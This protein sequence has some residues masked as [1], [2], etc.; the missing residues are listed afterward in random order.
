MWISFDLE[1]RKPKRLVICTLAHTA[2]RTKIIT[3]ICV[4]KGRKGAHVSVISSA[5]YISSISPTLEAEI[6]L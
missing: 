2:I 5:Q 1:T 3:S 4:H 6:S